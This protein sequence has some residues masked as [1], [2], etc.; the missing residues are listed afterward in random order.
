M[1]TALWQT[2]S[3]NDDGY[4]YLTTQVKQDFNGD[5]NEGFVFSGAGSAVSTGRKYGGVIYVYTNE[6]ALLWTPKSSTG[7]GYMIYIGDRWGDGEMSSSQETATI[8][9]KVF[10][11]MHF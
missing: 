9:V 11:G 7:R 4:F 3:H 2:F 5:D 10:D 6:S 8:I 1:T